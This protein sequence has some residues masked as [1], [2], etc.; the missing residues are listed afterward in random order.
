VPPPDAKATYANL[1]ATVVA[2]NPDQ[3]GLGVGQGGSAWLGPH[4]SLGVHDWGTR[5]GAGAGSRTPG[6]LEMI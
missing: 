3:V 5:P 2:I 4:T 1:L 6:E